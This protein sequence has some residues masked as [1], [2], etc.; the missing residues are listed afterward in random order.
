M[1]YIKKGLQDYDKYISGSISREITQQSHLYRNPF[2]SDQENEVRKY[3]V[4]KLM[5]GIVTPELWIN[6]LTRLS[7]VALSIV[8]PVS[9]NA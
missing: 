6:F 8:F 7:D 3:F 5:K 4:F 1:K 9:T 2:A